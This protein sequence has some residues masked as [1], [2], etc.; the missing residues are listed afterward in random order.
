MGQQLRA[1]PDQLITLAAAC[2]D[3]AATIGE[4]YRSGLREL[5][6]PADAFGNTAASAGL[7]SAAAAVGANAQPAVAGHV[8]ILEEDADALLQTAFAY[9]EADRAAAQTT[10]DSRRAGL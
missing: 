7:A 5:T 4:H 3:A 1:D 2:L 9:R 8:E 6:L 10:G